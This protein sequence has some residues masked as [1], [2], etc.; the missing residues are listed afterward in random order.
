MED[1]EPD[2]IGITETWI[3]SNMGIAEFSL[4]GYQMFRKDRA[5]RRCGGVALYIKLTA[6]AQLG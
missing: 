3:K 4:K 1:V 6:H 5:V 2:I